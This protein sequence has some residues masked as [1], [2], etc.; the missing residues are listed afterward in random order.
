[1]SGSD[2]NGSSALKS[3]SG[4][5]APGGGE[6]YVDFYGR[7]VYWNS[8]TKEE[9]EGIRAAGMTTTDLATGKK[10]TALALQKFG[11]GYYAKFDW[12]NSPYYDPNK[13]LPRID[14][15]SPAQKL[16]GPGAP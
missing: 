5:P 16:K 13:A 12:G 6:P 11:D 1:M 4:N 9:A 10:T 2:G 3:T 14:D 8:V 7:K 15:R